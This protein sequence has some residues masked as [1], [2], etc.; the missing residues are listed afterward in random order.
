MVPFLCVFIKNITNKL[1]SKWSTS[2]KHPSLIIGV[3]LTNYLLLMAG[4][5]DLYILYLFIPF[6]MF[7][8][9]IVWIS[10]CSSA[11]VFGLKSLH[12]SM[13]LLWKFFPPKTKECRNPCARSE[14]RSTW[15]GYRILV[16]EWRALRIIS[17][18]PINTPGSSIANNRVRRFSTVPEQLIIMD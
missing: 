2:P 3:S 15:I 16:L 9:V 13:T 5:K 7:Y 12:L 10:P 14:E 8:K 6:L 11:R 1:V 18:K 17:N 4:N